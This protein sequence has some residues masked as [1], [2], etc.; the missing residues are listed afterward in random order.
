MNQTYVHHS[1]YEWEGSLCL[2]LNSGRDITP[3][4][5]HNSHP[6]L[7]S[8]GRRSKHGIWI[9]QITPFKVLTWHNEP[10]EFGLWNGRLWFLFKR[11]GRHLTH[12]KWGDILN[13]GQN[14]TNDKAPSTYTRGILVVLYM[15]GKALGWGCYWN[16]GSHEAKSSATQV[17]LTHSPRALPCIKLG[18]SF[19]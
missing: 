8:V 6:P 1:V 3:I 12:Y 9:P 2:L 16:K 15:V 10:L 5:K 19:F 13:W 17:L 11:R 7:R 4:S 14:F 18:H